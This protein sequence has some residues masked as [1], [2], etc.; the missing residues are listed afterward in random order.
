M[1][2]ISQICVLIA[3]ILCT[4][5]QAV[6]LYSGE[7]E[8][9]DQ[10]A[11]ER[12]SAVQGALLQVLQKHSGMRELPLQPALDRALRN[13]SRMLL[14]F[15]YRSHERAQ[16]DG[17]VDTE[18]RL[19]ASFLP[20]AVEEVVQELELPRWRKERRPVTLW[21]VVDDGTG[22]DLMPMEYAYA[23]DALSDVAKARGLPIQWPELDEAQRNAV[24]LQLL[25][26][27]FTDELQQPQD[28]SAGVVIVAAR[29]EGPVWN[30]RW[31]FGGAERTA[32]WRI[33]DRDLG[34]A[35]VD[36]LHRLVDFVASRDAIA[37]S[38]QGDWRFDLRVAGL[39]DAA[40]YAR[41]LA[42]LE[43]LSVVDG[44]D[45]VEAGPGEVMFSLELN[46]MPTYLVSELERDRVLRP[47]AEVASRYVLTPRQG[48]GPAE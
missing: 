6:D 35:L 27:G 28:S 29:R 26:G 13:A 17:A 25:W 46:A 21:V 11:A 39:R 14:S 36:G 47:D 45:V 12:Q 38:E 41:C 4:Q 2:R 30:V 48:A 5:A 16:P 9:A 22:R 24:D 10:S 18:L 34:F 15:H 8:V 42:Y 7:V 43:G 44:L 20:Q 19:V 40:D 32:G 31:N 33:R 37:P 23:W 3:V 1:L